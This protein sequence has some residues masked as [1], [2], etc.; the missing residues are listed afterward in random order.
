MCSLF[1]AVAFLVRAPKAH[2][3]QLGQPRTH[4]AILTAARLLR[5][6]ARKYES[7]TP[8]AE[9]V[10]SAP[11]VGTMNPEHARAS[12]VHFWR[13]FGSVRK[14]DYEPRADFGT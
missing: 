12:V 7:S 8:A 5:G 13:V 10:T 4:P 3:G 11:K 14:P 9:N 6:L 1:E 2:R